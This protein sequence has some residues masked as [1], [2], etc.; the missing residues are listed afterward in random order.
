M[1]HSQDMSKILAVYLLKNYLLFSTE[2]KGLERIH[3]CLEELNVDYKGKPKR[4]NKIQ[5]S[6]KAIAREVIKKMREMIAEYE[7]TDS[8]DE[9]NIA[10]TVGE[11][12]RNSEINERHQRETRE[13]C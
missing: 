4:K 9:W 13:V 3:G 7:Q 6:K 1:F 8:I 2:V 11:D 10:F 12:Y 5:C